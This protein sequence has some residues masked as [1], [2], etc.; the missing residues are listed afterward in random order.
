M[1]T[2]DSMT[3]TNRRQFNPLKVLVNQIIDERE[4]EKTINKT[5]SYMQKFILVI[6]LDYL[7]RSAFYL[8]YQT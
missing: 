1:R 3:L 7:N 5:K 2:T 8:F 4:I 6:V